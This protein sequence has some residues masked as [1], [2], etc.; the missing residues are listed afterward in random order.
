MVMVIQCNKGK[1]I[2]AAFVTHTIPFLPPGDHFCCCQL[3]V[4]AFVTC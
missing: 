4:A 3:I 1:L 2:V